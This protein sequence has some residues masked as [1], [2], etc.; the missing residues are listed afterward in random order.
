MLLFFRRHRNNPD[1]TDHRDTDGLPI[2]ELVGD[3]NMRSDAMY[4]AMYVNG[5][6]GVDGV[7]EEGRGDDVV[8]EV[9]A[10]RR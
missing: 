5:E 6:E 7:E 3:A 1:A 2:F 4:D 10:V 8:E 9:G